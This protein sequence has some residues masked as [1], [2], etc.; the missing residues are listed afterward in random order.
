MRDSGGT[1][2]STTS[3]QVLPVPWTNYAMLW[4]LNPATSAAWKA[5]E[6]NLSELGMECMDAY[7]ADWDAGQ[8]HLL[9]AG[10]AGRRVIASDL[11]CTV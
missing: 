8:I 9:Y 4:A 7:Q 6:V 2:R 10:L 11:C 1:D 5:A 3:A